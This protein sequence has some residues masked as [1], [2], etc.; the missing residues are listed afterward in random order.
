MLVLYDEN[1]L[2][3]FASTIP[4]AAVTANRRPAGDTLGPLLKKHQL[5]LRTQ[6]TPQPNVTFQFGGQD[7]QSPRQLPHKSLKVSRG[8]TLSLALDS[9]RHAPERWKMPI[10]FSANWNGRPVRVL[11]LNGPHFSQEVGSGLEKETGTY[12][13]V[14]GYSITSNKD[15][16]L[17]VDAETGFPLVERSE[18]MEFQ[19]LDYTEVSPGQ[20]APLRIICKTRA[21]DMDLRFQVLDGKLWLFDREAQLKNKS[22]VSISEILIDGIKPSKVIRSRIP[23]SQVDLPWF[24]WNELKSRQPEQN[25]DQL[26]ASFAAFTKPWTHPS[27]NNLTEVRTEADSDGKLL[28][29]CSLV[30]THHSAS[31]STG[32]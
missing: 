21:F 27:W 18:T 20:F 15:L 8:I 14:G 9:I 16:V 4:E 11:G 5:W 28:L 7:E 22:K 2:P 17:V 6:D 13:Y 23:D 29:H 10:V 12:S 19:F 30:S 31:Q 24:P 1:R 25:G 26:S 3:L 32:H